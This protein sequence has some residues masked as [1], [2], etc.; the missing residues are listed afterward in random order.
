MCS[1]HD[2]TE[3]DQKWEHITQYNQ[4]RIEPPKASMRPWYN[5]VGISRGCFMDAQWPSFWTTYSLSYPMLVFITCAS[6]WHVD[7]NNNSDVG[8]S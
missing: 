4:G 7:N 6:C 3:Y 5:R 2:K 1:K 8:M